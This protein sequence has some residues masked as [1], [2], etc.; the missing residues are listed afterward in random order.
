MAT[1]I[2]G[3]R[4]GVIQMRFFSRI[5]QISS[6]NISLLARKNYNIKKEGISPLYLYRFNSTGSGKPHLNIGTIGHVDH[7]KTTLTAAITKVLFD[8]GL[9]KFVKFDEIDRAPEEKRRG[10]TIN[11]T[12]VEYETKNRHYAHTDCPGHIDF[13]KNMI[14][15]ASQIDGAILVVAAT[16]G[17]MP[18]TRE[19]LLLVKQIGVK[20]VIVFINKADAVDSEMVELVELETRDLLNELGYNGEEVPFIAGSAL[21]ALNGVDSEFG[22]KAVMKLINIIDIEV[23]I[24]ERNLQGPF[25]MP[26]EAAVGISGRGTVVIGTLKQGVMIKGEEAVLIGHGSMIKTALSDLQVF[27][28]SVQKCVAG[29]NL[30]ALLRGVKKELVERGMFLCKP[31]A[32]KQYDSFEAQ[33]YIL[34]KA[35]GGRSK[36]IIDGYIQMMYSNTWS[37]GCCVKLFADTKMLM[38]GD[39]AKINLLL[40]M[41]MVLEEGMKFTIRENQITTITGIITKPLPS[42]KLE[43]MGFNAIPKK[44]VKIE[45]NATSVR[46]RR[47]RSQ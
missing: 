31:E 46:N 43:I 36:P 2:V 40:R 44:A 3:M 17:I 28:K 5:R 12:H 19:H 24:P 30:G 27:K 29:D 37:M 8:E 6:K 34:S 47:S 41:P 18:Q 16:D 21:H 10:I 9:S 4:L 23:K 7:G 39:T 14:T 38:P 32:F 35:E 1:A 26:V 15:G 13:I 45:G 20:N 33:V 11:A 22:K 25:Y 42:L